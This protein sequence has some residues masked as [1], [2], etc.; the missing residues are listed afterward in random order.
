MTHCTPNAT[1]R[2]P[3]ALRRRLGRSDEVHPLQRILRAH[4]LHTVCEEARCPNRAECFSHGT[5]TFMIC[6][7]RCTRSCHFCN[8]TTARPYALD[9]HEPEKLARA[10]TLMSLNHVVITS[11]DRDDL[12]DGGAAHWAACIRAVRQALPQ[13][14]V[15]VLTPDFKG[16]TEHLDVVLEAGPHVFN[17]NI[18]TVPRLYHS[19]RPQ[20]YF[21]TSIRVLRHAAGFGGKRKSGLMVG[22]GESDDEVFATLET[23]A[24]VGLDIA[25][26]GQYLRPTLQHWEVHR[27]VSQESFDAFKAHGERAGIPVVFSGAFVRSS[28]HAGETFL[29]LKARPTPSPGRLTVLP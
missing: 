19:L 22:L 26:V 3:E 14:T 24:E 12:P 5:A 13:A 15:E 9:P 29:E 27:Y 21:D 11:V 4:D 7:D 8:V 23:L 17:H 2:L 16:R 20:S 10:A 18:E 25:T 28:Y 6:G 1:L